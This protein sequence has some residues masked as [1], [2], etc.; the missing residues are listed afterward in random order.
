MKAFMLFGHRFLILMATVLLISCS[1]L[2]VIRHTDPAAAAD[3]IQRCRRPF[4][5]IP[6]RVVHSIEAALPGGKT[7]TVVGVTV[8]DPAAGTIHSVIM[9]IEGFVLFDA[10]HDKGELRVDRAAAPFD[11]G[12]FAA[13]IMEDVRLIFLAP[14][15]R[16]ADAGLLENGSSICRYYENQD[17][18]VDVVVH[19]DDTWEIET[20]RASHERLRKIRAFSVHDRIPGILELTGFESSNYSLRLKLISAEPVTAQEPGV[21]SQDSE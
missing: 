9:T 1:S 17:R 8:F 11:G 21:R 10:R 12:H 4:L 5:D 16:L 15:G 14:Q 2:S 13:H 7:G 19:Q 20:Y 3:A 18:I 6:Y